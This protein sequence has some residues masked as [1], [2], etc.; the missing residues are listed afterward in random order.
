MKRAPDLLDNAR[1]RLEK[2]QL[3]Q[4]VNDFASDD[5]TRAEQ[6]Y[7]QAIRLWNSGAR[8]Q[9]GETAKTVLSHLDA[10]YRAVARA[11]AKNLSHSDWQQLRYLQTERAVRIAN[12]VTVEDPEAEQEEDEDD[13]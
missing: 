5:L 7:S 6:S 1:V 12:P 8:E 9:A 2:A 4:R 11:A 10:A 3:D 13:L